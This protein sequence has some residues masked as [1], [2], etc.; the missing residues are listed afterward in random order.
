MINK[1]ISKRVAFGV[2][3]LCA[4][5]LAHGA[6]AQDAAPTAPVDRL[7]NAVKASGSSGRDLSVVRETMLRESAMVL[8]AREGLR[9][10]SCL[11][12][13]EIIRREADYDRTYRFADLMMGR[14]ILPPVIT[15]AKNSVSLTD[16]VLRVASAVY[17]LDAPA[18]VVDVPPTWRD[19]INVGLSTDSCDGAPVD[20]PSH[21]QLKPQNAAEE[22]FFRTVLAR[23]YQAGVQQARDILAD[24]IARLERTYK[25]MRAYYDLYSR[26]MVSAPMIASSTDVAL[27]DDP[28]TLVVGNTVIRITVPANF[29]DKSSNWRPLG[30]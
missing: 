9:V 4:I 13:K 14:G 6:K 25:G 20:V 15:E 29:V 12:R 10:Q 3:A 1:S 7:M 21:D 26:G 27:L 5:V 19:W 23:S 28:N 24:N 22:A 16:T 17:H 30:E 11:I 18:R 2:I 8:G